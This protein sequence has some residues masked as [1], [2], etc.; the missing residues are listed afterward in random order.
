MNRTLEYARINN[1]PISAVSF[2]PFFNEKKGRVA[3]GPGKANGGWREVV[4][5]Y[6]ENQK[7]YGAGATAWYLDLEKANM[8]VV[9]VDTEDGMTA[10]EALTEDAYQRFY[11]ASSYVVETGSGG[12]HF[13][14]QS[15]GK[16]LTKVVDAKA[17]QKY[18]RDGVKGGIDLITDYIVIEGSS[19]EYEG[20]TYAYKAVKPGAT[21]ASTTFHQSVWEEVE[22]L[23]RPKNEVVVPESPLPAGIS[24][25]EKEAYDLG[26]EKM[27]EVATL[28]SLFSEERATNYDSWI[29][30]GFALKGLYH[31]LSEGEELFLTFSQKSDKYREGDCRRAYRAITPRSSYTKKSLFYWAKEDSPEKYREL[32]A[33]VLTWDHLKYMNQ[34]EMAKIFVGL[35]DQEFVYSEECWFRYNEHN[36]L[37]RLGKGHPDGLKRLVSDRLQEE[38]HRAVKG[39]K[40]G[41]E[42]YL[43]CMKL[44]MDAHKT[45]GQ[46]QWINGVI[47]FVRG[48]YTDDDLYKT[49]DT[50]TDLLAFSNGLLLDNS[51]KTIRLIQ[52][53]DC[54]SRTTGKPLTKESSE[55]IRKMIVAELLN[56]FDDPQMVTYWLETVGMALFTNRYEKLYCHT[57]SGGNGKGVLFGMLKEALGAYYYQAPN[58][59]LT[60]TYKADAPNS[61]L[62]N[63]RGVRIF[64][65]SEP[66]SQNSDGRGIRLSTDLIK[67]LSGGDD[68]NARDLHCSAKSPYKPTFTSFLQCNAIPDFTKVDGGLRR[69]FEKMDYPNKFVEE[70]TRK[71]EKQMDYDLKRKMTQYEVINEF[72]LLLWDTAK[73]FTEF[74]RPQSV[75][76]STKAFLDDSDKVLC[77]L[78]EKMEKTDELPPVGERITKAEAVKMYLS[79]TGARITPKVFHDQMRVNEVET[80]K[81]GVEYYLLKRLP[82]P[83]APSELV[84][85]VAVPAPALGLRQPTKEEME[86]GRKMPTKEQLEATKKKTLRE[87]V[88]EAGDKWNPKAEGDTFRL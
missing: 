53:E 31:D 36:T 73:S 49:I 40:Q 17:L 44:G 24:P 41:S 11:D 45:F 48:L 65:T 13:Y 58:E 55:P 14:F 52:R 37:V 2:R 72:I 51:T 39:L 29:K 9:D 83:D 67:A 27:K 46:S 69:R 54:I 88:K 1:I 22:G 47:D 82:E 74:H 33:L 75:K 62:A 60:T 87:K 20:K 59:F 42:S 8:Y 16:K 30:V 57:G 23:C 78:E 7:Y 35:V 28:V 38:A 70:P 81:S 71:N 10:Q 32:Y 3:K 85:P 61:T 26:M 86:V 5:F 50:N 18:F 12:A 80:K 34:N 19:Y 77:W 84:I 56:I 15:N 76:E 68:I 25:I 4:G 66:S 43:P 64:M 63:A 6:H 79:D 21:I